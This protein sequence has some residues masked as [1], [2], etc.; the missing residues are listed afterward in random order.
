MEKPLKMC[1]PSSWQDMNVLLET[2][3]LTSKAYGV[4]YND[5]ENNVFF[6]RAK[7][8]WFVIDKEGI[9]RYTKSTDPGDFDKIEEVL[10][11][12]SKLNWGLRR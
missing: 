5:P 3:R 8:S 6:R 12:L 11:V 2:E 4:L 9:I 1:L 7:R 10:Q